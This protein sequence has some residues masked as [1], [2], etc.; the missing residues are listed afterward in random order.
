MSLEAWAWH[1]TLFFLVLFFFLLYN[2]VLVLP[3]INMNLPRVYTCSPP[4]TPLPP[5]TIPLGHPNAPAP[6]ILYHAEYLYFECLYL[7]SGFSLKHYNTSHFCQKKIRVSFATSTEVL[8]SDL[9][10]L[11][12]FSQDHGRKEIS[13][14]FLKLHTELE[15]RFIY[16]VTFL[17]CLLLLCGGFCGGSVV[18]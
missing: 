2:I 4:W 8:S 1:W 5:H 10:S 15:Q 7:S 13:C 9:T 17:I 6:S 16:L 3:Y 18:S 14:C 11:Q 12:D